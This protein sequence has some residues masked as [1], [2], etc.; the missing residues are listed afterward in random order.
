MD[1][2]KKEG[3]VHVKKKRL[4]RRNKTFSSKNVY[5]GFQSLGVSC[6]EEILL[7]KELEK[8]VKRGIH[9]QSMALHLYHDG[10][11]V[12]TPY[13]LC[14]L[15]VAFEKDEII[16][17]QST[18]LTIA[19]ATASR[20]SY[21]QTLKTRALKEL[22]N[23]EYGLQAD[24]MMARSNLRLEYENAASKSN[25]DLESVRSGLNLIGQE[26]SSLICVLCEMGKSSWTRGDHY[27]D[28]AKIIR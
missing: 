1:A 2:R 23:L 15:E 20:Q 11:E 3:Q 21:S 7:L 5:N 8:R 26:V 27:R 16:L 28:S 12:F 9:I 13:D 22:C 17:S 10:D 6:K 25:Q 19:A 14:L 18:I 4:R 24:T